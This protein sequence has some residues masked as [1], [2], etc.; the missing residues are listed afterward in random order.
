MTRI[1]DIIKNLVSTWGKTPY[2]INC[3]D[4]IEFTESIIE[5][6]GGDSDDLY[7]L[8]TSNFDPEWLTGLPL[9]SWIFYKGR[10]YDAETPEGV[11]DWRGLS[12]FAKF[13]G[14]VIA[15]QILGQKGCG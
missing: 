3:G 14:V 5:A 12:I 7:E 1:T 10:H 4:C 2:D 15:M 9:H 11:D 13:D 6:M 8:C